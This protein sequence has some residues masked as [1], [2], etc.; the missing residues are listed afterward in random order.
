MPVHPECVN[1]SVGAAKRLETL[2]T[3]ARIM[4]YMR[5]RT[6]LDRAHGLD[7]GRAPPAALVH[8][9]RH[10]GRQDGAERGS[11]GLCGR[12]LGMRFRGLRLC[13][14]GVTLG[15]KIV[16]GCSSRSFSV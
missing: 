11:L 6:E 5:R 16:A 3:R 4:Q 9:Y 1:R 2:E 10:V 14:H 8:G 12:G 15:M 7:L 13:I